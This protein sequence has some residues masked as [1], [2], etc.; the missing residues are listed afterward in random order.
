MQQLLALGNTD[1]Y[2]T[3]EDAK[4]EHE[5]LKEAKV[6]Y[7]RHLCG[8]EKK[9]ATGWTYGSMKQRS[10]A[11]R[12]KLVPTCLLLQALDPCVSAPHLLNGGVSL[13]P[14]LLGIP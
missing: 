8:G 11:G 12:C 1:R 13:L 9:Q 6:G 2:N 3:E 14:S 4:S 10:R 5:D 7:R